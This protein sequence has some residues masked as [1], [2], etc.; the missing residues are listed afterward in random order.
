MIWSWGVFFA[1]SDSRLNL[2]SWNF[3]YSLWM[4]SCV[5]GS[6]RAALATPKCTIHFNTKPVL[7]SL[8]VH[9]V[10][11]NW[12]SKPGSR[13]TCRSDIWPPASGW[14]PVPAEM[15]SSRTKR[16]KRTRN[17]LQMEYVSSHSCLICAL[18]LLYLRYG[19][20]YSKSKTHFLTH[21][22]SVPLILSRTFTAL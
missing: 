7:R 22:S 10:S 1:K 12:K 19:L 5:R 15:K 21:Y 11:N 18:C 3:A 4:A 8:T 9:D 13:K 14:P 6:S 20:M 17:L 2:R 16:Q